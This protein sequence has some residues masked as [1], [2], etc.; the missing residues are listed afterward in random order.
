VVDSGGGGSG[1]GW[2]VSGS[3]WYVAATA[4]LLIGG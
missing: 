1:S 4:I 2:L 3:M